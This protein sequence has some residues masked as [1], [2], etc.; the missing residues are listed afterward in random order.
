MSIEAN[1][2]LIRRLVEEVL[3]KGNMALAPEL[4][5]PT[6]IYHASYAQDMSGQEVLTK[7]VAGN[8]AAFPDQRVTVDDLVA[9]GDKVLCRYT[10]TGTNTGALIGIPPTGKKVIFSGMFVDRVEGG[11]VVETWGVQDQLSMWRQLG[12]IPPGFESAK[13]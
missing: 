6:W 10:I 4:F 2:A 8:R 12:T 13:K 7:V 1:K 9:E 3:D 11:K 5:G